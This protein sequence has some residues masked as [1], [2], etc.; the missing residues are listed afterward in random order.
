MSVGHYLLAPVGTAEVRT[1]YCSTDMGC[2]KVVLF[3]T[4]EHIILV[5][6]SVLVVLCQDIEYRILA[7][8]VVLFFYDFHE[9]ER[10]E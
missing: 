4:E 2:Y 8:G 5:L 9:L 7:I 6:L 10:H 1:S 3:V